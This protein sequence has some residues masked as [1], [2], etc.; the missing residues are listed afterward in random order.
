MN[1]ENMNELIEKLLDRKIIVKLSDKDAGEFKWYDN[2]KEQYVIVEYEFMVTF[3]DN[4][5][6]ITDLEGFSKDYIGDW[7]GMKFD[8]KDES[9]RVDLETVYPDGSIISN[10]YDVNVWRKESL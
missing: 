4:D 10:I 6:V 2:T 5:G 8:Y 3:C 1:V 7:H 9:Y